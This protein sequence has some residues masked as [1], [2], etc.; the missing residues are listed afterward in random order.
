[1]QEGEVERKVRELTEE[2]FDKYNANANKVNDDEEPFIK[3]DDLKQFIK[4]IM[5]ASGEGDAWDEDAFTKGYAE[6]D[7]DG[8]GNIEQSEF[9]AFI[10]RYADL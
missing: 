4:E 7:A 2:V 1:M 9:E 5:E 10:K 3:K 6:F 8:Q